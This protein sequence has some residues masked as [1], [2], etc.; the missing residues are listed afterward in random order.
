V[1]RRVPRQRARP[2]PYARAR[3]MPRTV[4]RHLG[5][6]RK[7]TATGVLTIFVNHNC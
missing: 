6:A 4:R 7:R 3:H 2:R 5:T 1:V